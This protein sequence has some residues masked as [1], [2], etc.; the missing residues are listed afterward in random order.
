MKIQTASQA[1]TFSKELEEKGADFYKKAGE[2]FEQA[3]DLFETFAKENNK[4]F[5]QI[6]RAYVSVITDAIEGCYAVDIETKDYEVDTEIPDSFEETVKKA[7]EMEKKIIEYYELAAKQSG[8][9]MADVP[10]TFKIVAR[11]RK[12]NRIPQLES[13]LKK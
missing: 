2:K 9:L 1:I 8:S 12:Q 7:L 6:N 5:Q 10:R 11:K 13:W 4:F 3:R